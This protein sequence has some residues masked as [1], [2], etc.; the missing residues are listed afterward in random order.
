MNGPQHYAEAERLLGLAESEMEAYANAA[1]ASA[2]E[3]AHLAQSGWAQKRAQ[4]HATLALTAATIDAANTVDVTYGN[5]VKGRMP[6][7]LAV[8]GESNGQWDEVLR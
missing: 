8:S 7:D 5:G 4:V 2:T 1:E 3:A 6:M